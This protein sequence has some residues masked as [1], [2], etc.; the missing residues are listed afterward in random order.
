MH[1]T[2]TFFVMTWSLVKDC[3]DWTSS[4]RSESNANE[5]W[6]ISHTNCSSFKW[7]WYSC[8]H[9]FYLDT[10]YFSLII[11]YSFSKLTTGLWPYLT[12]FFLKNTLFDIR[13]FSV[14]DTANNPLG[15]VGGIIWGI[16][17]SNYQQ[18]LPKCKLCC[19][20]IEL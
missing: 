8:H 13:I 19:L 15:N 6:W 1:T 5:I 16:F 10:D 12:G 14:F 9:N 18:F 7:F 17:S 4:F 11:Y 3:F 2:H 20:R